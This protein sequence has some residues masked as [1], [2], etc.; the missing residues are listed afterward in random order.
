MRLPWWSPA[1]WVGLCLLWRRD[2]GIVALL[3]YHAL[4]LVAVL[5]ARPRLAWGR[6]PRWGWGV[7]IPMA[8][9]APS[10]LL[11]PKVPGFSLDHLRELVARW[12]GGLRTH[13]LY[14]LLV[15]VPLEEALWRAAVEQAHPDWTPTRHGLAFGLHHLV[16]AGLALGWAAA[17][18]ALLLPAAAGAF[19]AWCTRRQG[20]LGLPIATHALADLGLM[21]L[22]ASQLR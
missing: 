16:G 18:P 6:W 11:L 4:C 21:A 5:A 22:A 1:L 17:L 10:M 9:L 13:A 15:N 19:W 3:G 12:P 2:A 7:L 20:G 8:I 14:V